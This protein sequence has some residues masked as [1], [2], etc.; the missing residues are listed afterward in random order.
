[1]GVIGNTAN[2]RMP[3]NIYYEE[4]LVAL[5]TLG[6]IGWRGNEATDF[7]GGRD[8][9]WQEIEAISVKVY[10]HLNPLDLLVVRWLESGFEYSTCIQFI[11]KPPISLSWTHSTTRPPIDTVSIR[12]LAVLF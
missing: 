12:F 10:K 11:C 8:I 7:T 3:T 9:D 4:K 2:K 5:S 1:M 6:L